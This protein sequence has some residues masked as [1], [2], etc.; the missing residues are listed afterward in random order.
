M[1]RSLDWMNDDK[2]LGE[3]AQEF[4][5]RKEIPSITHEEFVNMDF[6]KALF[7]SGIINA[8][9]EK[10]QNTLRDMKTVKGRGRR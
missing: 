5:L 6:E 9:A 3:W 4:F 10:E 7:F 2:P 1:E 8:I